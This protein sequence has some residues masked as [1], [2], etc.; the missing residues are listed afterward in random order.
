MYFTKRSG[1]DNHEKIYHAVFSKVLNAWKIDPDPLDFCTNRSSY[2]NPTLSADGT[3][4]VFS[5][6]KAGS[7]GGMDLWFT[8]KVG[9]TWKEPENLGDKINTK[10]NE[11]F[12]HLDPENNLYFSSNG[13][14]GCGGYDIFLSRYTG[15]R[16]EKPVNLT[17]PIN[18]ENDELAFTVNPNDGK[19][20][21]FTARQKSRTGKIQLYMVSLNEET[22]IKDSKMLSDVLYSISNPEIGSEKLKL[23]SNKSESDSIEKAKL[24]AGEIEALKLKAAKSRTDSIETSKLKARDINATKIRAI[25]RTDSIDK[26]RSKSREIDAARIRAA[27]SRTDSLLALRID[28]ERSVSSNRTNDDIVIY[29]VQFLASMKSKGTF[30]I[31]VNEKKYTTSEYFYLGAFR[32]TIGEFSTLKPAAEL[33]NICRKYG[34][35]QAFVVAFKNNVRSND[36][37]LFK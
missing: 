20:A 1:A 34:Q 23:A 35:P 36:L 4:M 33:Q 27:K 7:F 26:T 29:K 25:S 31:T 15:T 37:K 8:R 24:I 11:L 17:K 22:G 5:S 12:P 9:I 13:L 3:I 14:P 16:W 32:Y 18:S 30:E 2:S 21:F 28:K 6:D 10:G 19:S